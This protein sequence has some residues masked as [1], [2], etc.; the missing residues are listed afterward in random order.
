MASHSRVKSISS[1][2]S[3]NS[4][5]LDRD[6]CSDPSR[7]AVMNPLSKHI[8]LITG[9]E[10]P[11][12]SRPQSTVLL[13]NPLA[14]TENIPDNSENTTS[15]H[16]NSPKTLPTNPPGPP[17]VSS[18]SVVVPIASPTASPT[19]ALQS[20]LDLAQGL[21]R[22]KTKARPSQRFFSKILRR[23]SESSDKDEK[24]VGED[25]DEGWKAGVFGYVPNFPTPPKYI[26]VRA[27]HKKQR[28]FNRLFLAQ[29]LNWKSEASEKEPKKSTIWCARFSLDG[30]YLA[31]AGADH[32]VR[33][34][35][36]I[37][38][39]EERDFYNEDLS[40]EEEEL[41]G[42]HRRGSI[43]RQKNP[44][45]SAPVFL[46]FPIREYVGH[47]ADV[48]DLSW[49][50]NNFLLSSSMDK[51]VHLWHVKMPESIASFMHSDFVTS[52]VFHPNDDRFFLS[53]SLDCRLRLW[54]IP[55]KK[56][57]YI[58]RAP[59]LIMAV[60]FTPDGNTAIAGCFGGQ[61]LTY[62]TIGLSLIN[63]MMI[64]KSAHGKNSN[65][66]KITGIEVL[67]FPSNY[68]RHPNST[69]DYKLLIS[70]NDS[71]IRLYNFKDGSL[72]SKFKGHEN[73]QG[74]IRASFSGNGTYV[75]SGSE[76]DRTYI[77]KVRKDTVESSKT[78]EDYE[79]FHSNN[80]VVTVALFAPDV[81][82]SLLYNSRDPIYD[83]ADPPPVILTRQSSTFP[84][85]DSNVATSNSSIYSNNSL[86]PA[87]PYKPNPTDGNVIITADQD[88]MIKVFRQD[89]AYER[90]KLRLENATM[91]QKKK[92]GGITLSPTLSSR[93]SIKPSLSMRGIS[94]RPP[95]GGRT[96]RQSDV[97][98]SASPRLTFDNSNNN[99]SN[100]NSVQ[101]PAGRHQVY[102]Q[103]PVL[104]HSS[105]STNLPDTTLRTLHR[106]NSP[107]S[108]SSLE[109]STQA[110]RVKRQLQNF[111]SGSGNTAI[112]TTPSRSS[113][114]TNNNNSSIPP[115]PIANNIPSLDLSESN[116]TELGDIK[117]KACGNNDFKARTTRNGT[118]AL[119][120][121]K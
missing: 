121:S 104:S 41:V 68:R 85:Q 87:T 107:S 117:C 44:N 116:T 39:P 17:G 15:A 105:S 94:P 79:Y 110:L 6:D 1:K 24:D 60:A 93:S 100:T 40:G 14:A 13:S 90:R 102:P 72:V 42:R 64:V 12:S 108:L 37:S 56:M 65:G 118:M 74:L 101:Y 19:H 75:I 96:S 4:H 30:K 62:E 113:S 55:E 86:P 9:S 29:E 48:L 18:N 92:I 38:T 77:W 45:V 43:R 8:S 106:S 82:R 57:A 47:T 36:V 31:T 115:P 91:I 28:E 34:W 52:I 89:S 71:R 7:M 2:I 26:W 119:M 10:T 112:G 103:T 32:I 59:D 27:H 53:G 114:N 5:H 111:Q 23:K 63:Q 76:D 51:T 67:T 98:L 109:L 20:P 61:C 99:T 54:S 22:V 49:S 58:S 33:V 50:K 81:T 69:E 3:V 84:E 83:I 46:P 70:T 73:S 16:E 78:R 95:G 66:C 120:C 80:S 21:P 97:G 25:R 88:G 11:S 35:Q